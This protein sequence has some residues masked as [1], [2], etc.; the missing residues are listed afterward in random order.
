MEKRRYYK[1]EFKKYR[2]R[3]AIRSFRDLEVYQ[4]TTQLASEIFKLKLPKELQEEQNNL[5]KL[6]QTPPQLISESYGKKFVNIESGLGKL[7]QASQVIANI[8]SR[9]DFLVASVERAETKESL[10]K[11]LHQYQKQKRKILNLKRAWEKAFLPRKEKT[12]T[13]AV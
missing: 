9:I 1:R 13:N 8:I 4:K 3:T 7:E 2:V 11:I 6:S 5:K 10:V 12:L